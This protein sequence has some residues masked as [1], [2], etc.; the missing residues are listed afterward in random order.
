MEKIIMKICA[1]EDSFGAY[2]ENCDGIWAAGDTV[3]AC[4]A[5]VEEAIRLIKK[6]LPESQ[7]PEQIKGDYEIEWQYDTES[8]MYYYGGL[9]SLSGMERITG[10]NQ[11]Q[12]WAYMHGRKKP[13]QA[14]KEKIVNSLHK[15][16]HDLASAVMF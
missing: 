9:I 16:A 13:R 4:K 14:Q 8:F 10:I 3:E 1:S 6:N 5:D 2:S 7:W 15:F 12:L 11:K